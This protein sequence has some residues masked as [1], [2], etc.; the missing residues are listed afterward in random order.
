[1]KVKSAVNIEMYQ[2]ILSVLDSYD[3]RNSSEIEL[4]KDR[5]AYAQNISVVLKG[6]VLMSTVIYKGK[7][8]GEDLI[9][10]YCTLFEDE[11][12][13]VKAVSRR[14]R[15]RQ[16]RDRNDSEY[17]Y[18]IDSIEI[19]YTESDRYDNHVVSELLPNYSISGKTVLL[20]FHKDYNPLTDSLDE[21]EEQPFNDLYLYD[22]VI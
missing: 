16:Q 4:R 3:L 12:D 1:M 8:L 22:K 21:P 9:E 20:P 13:E 17:E 15:A 5:S 6:Q 19:E 2:F 14:P 11:L 7:A 18:M 10:Y